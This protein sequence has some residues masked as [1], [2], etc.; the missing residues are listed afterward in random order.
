MSLPFNVFTP[1]FGL[2]WKF[3]VGLSDA[4]KIYP[5]LA[6]QL[7]QEHRFILLLHLVRKNDRAQQDIS[8]APDGP[9]ITFSRNSAEH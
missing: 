3:P 5:S 8:E 1:R 4:F 6:T 2:D 7:C 9:T